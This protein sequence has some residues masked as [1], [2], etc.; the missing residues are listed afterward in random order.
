[1]KQENP[2]LWR[3]RA[4][5]ALRP[6]PRPGRFVV[7]R[8]QV[9][10]LVK[11][12]AKLTGIGEREIAVL[13]AHLSVLTKGPVS[14]SQLLISYA[15]VTGLLER[16]NCMDERRFR[17]GEARLEQLGFLTRKLSA[18]ARR[19]PVRDGSGRVVD[20]YGVDL[21]PL[22]LKIAELEDMR[23][24]Q[25]HEA[26]Q[27][28][29]LTTRISARVSAVKRRA[30]AV[31][32]YI[33]E[34]LAATAQAV[35][36]LLRRTGVSPSEMIMAEQA[37][38]ALETELLSEPSPAPTPVAA[39]TKTADDRQI[40]RHI[41]SPKKETTY[42]HS[43]Q[44]RSN[45]QPI[46][47]IWEKC[48]E[49]SAVFPERPRNTEELASRLFEFSS[50]LGLGQKVVGEALEVLGIARF[51]M[52]LDYLAGRIHSIA[53]PQ[54]YLKNMLKKFLIGEAIAGGCVVLDMR[55]YQHL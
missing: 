16:A 42:E 38:V 54:G 35:R 48:T 23:A 5:D 12:T 31:L 52:V 36:N 44:R 4:E 41:E 29:A 32:G 40:D 30:I 53:K 34:V 50:F 49:I 11:D 21:R 26:Q 19:F 8:W 33:P 45:E 3:D 14:A 17:R 10:Q 24:R 7:D 39:D 22:F 43:K 25:L 28:R 47:T 20:A 15:Q 13:G 9:L 1:M 51:L 55:Q 18:N 46:S 27:L 6:A 37:L 2:T